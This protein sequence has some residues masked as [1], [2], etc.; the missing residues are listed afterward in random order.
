M[1]KLNPDKAGSIVDLPESEIESLKKVGTDLSQED[2]H[3][4]FDMAL[5]GGNDIPRSSD[6]RIVL[7]MLLLRMAAAPRIES[8]LH[9][10]LGTTA[11][12]SSERPTKFTP[13]AP[14]KPVPSRP[15]PKP[16]P[17]EVKKETPPPQVATTEPGSPQDKWAQLVA[18]VKKVNGV[19]GAKLEHSYLI[20][21]TS[22][23][24][25]RVGIPG[26]MKFLYDQ[27]SNEK[28]LNK[29]SNYMNTFW[30]PGF[31][32]EVAL[33]D[34]SA[35]KKPLTPRGI[36]EKRRAEKAEKARKEVE[37]HPLVQSTKRVFKSEI[38]SIKE[39]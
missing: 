7:E 33:G 26:K 28:F 11:S 6:P 36:E 14:T 17:Q 2:V 35:E 9:G 1:V 24:K 23:K 13:Q 15:T 5:K 21:L 31:Q 19:I 22:E 20:E 25:V 34:S 27:V 8:L 32:I 39:M 30:G 4:L 16:S 37:D 38:Q 29:L 12:T 3:M 18:R 10:G